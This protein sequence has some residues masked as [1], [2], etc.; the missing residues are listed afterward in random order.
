[1]QN[2]EKEGRLSSWFPG[3]FS[4]RN[5]CGFSEK[6]SFMDSLEVFGWF[7][8]GVSDNPEWFPRRESL[9]KPLQVFFS[10]GTFNE[11]LM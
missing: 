11:S 1:M 2:L 6:K 7:P 8:G 9:V 5:I 3:R 4:H 10:G